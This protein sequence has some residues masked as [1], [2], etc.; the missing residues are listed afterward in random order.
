L[1]LAVFQYSERATADWLGKGFDADTQMLEAITSGHFPDSPAG[2]YLATIKSRFKG[3]IVADLLCYLRLHTELALRAKGILMMRETGF[4]TPVDEATVSKLEEM[5]YLE[6]SIGKTGRLALR[7]LLRE[8]RQEIWQL[9]MLEDASVATA[10][11]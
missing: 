3:P 10:T 9:R 5:H 2:Q 7:P 1:L 11:K 4:D 8:G 6:G